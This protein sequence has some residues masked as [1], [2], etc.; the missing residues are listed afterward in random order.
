MLFSAIISSID[1]LKS[2]R[3]ST[4]AF[5]TA[6]LRL[7][8]DPL[9]LALLLLTDFLVDIRGERS[10]SLTP[11]G[12]LTAVF[13]AVVVG[14]VMIGRRSSSGGGVKVAVLDNL[15]LQGLCQ[16]LLNDSSGRRT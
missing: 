8:D 14:L 3:G 6:L 5:T 9:L 11:A 1:S 12:E 7:A 4:D 10:L 13:R 2:L 16:E 15:E